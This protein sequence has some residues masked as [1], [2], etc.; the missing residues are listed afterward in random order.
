[1]LKA[2]P[3]F[4]D[5]YG[6]HPIVLD[7]EAHDAKRRSAIVQVQSD[8]VRTI[9]RS[10]STPHVE[11]ETLQSG[12]EPSC[13]LDKTGVYS[14]RFQ[15]SIPRASFANEAHCDFYG[16]LPDD[17]KGELLAYWEAQLYR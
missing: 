1:V 10:T 17:A 15:H 2:D 8:M 12:P 16:A 5:I 4:A 11:G 7:K 6:L 3:E 13:R 9:G 14:F